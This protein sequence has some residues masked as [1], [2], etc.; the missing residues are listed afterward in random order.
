MCLPCQ[1]AGKIRG[2]SASKKKVTLKYSSR[3]EREGKKETMPC[4][5]EGIDKYLLKRNRSG[6]HKD[7][8]Q[9]ES[10]YETKKEIPI[11]AVVCPQGKRPH[12]EHGVSPGP[13]PR[14]ALPSRS[15]LAWGS[16][17]ARPTPHRPRARGGG[18][19][20]APSAQPRPSRERAISEHLSPVLGKALGPALRGK[21]GLRG[22]LSV[23]APEPGILEL[24]PPPET[25]ALRL[26][27]SEPC[28][29]RPREAASSAKQQAARVVLP[30]GEARSGS[31]PAEWGRVPPPP[32]A[33]AS[34]RRDRGRAGGSARSANGRRARAPS[35]APGGVGAG[36][37]PGRA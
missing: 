36:P 24:E 10:L 15:A 6:S 12:L 25:S 14:R 30:P 27:A 21:K 16:F 23:S 4:T 18:P 28:R 1:R 22:R 37:P 31:E 2:G 9:D 33:A 34:A 29:G 20:G 26:G 13:G 35:P 32:R 17:P 3:G 7:P 5:Q 19:P 11:W 8:L